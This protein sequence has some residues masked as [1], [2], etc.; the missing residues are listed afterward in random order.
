MECTQ[1]FSNTFNH[2]H[3]LQKEMHKHVM[4][5]LNVMCD[6]SNYYL[7]SSRLNQKRGNCKFGNIFVPLTL[8]FMH[9]EIVSI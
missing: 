8:K 2:A 7:N 1:I 9:K 4:Y 5:I 6:R 3:H